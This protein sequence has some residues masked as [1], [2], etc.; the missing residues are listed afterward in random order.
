VIAVTYE[1]QL[2]CCSLEPSKQ[3]LSYGNCMPKIE[4]RATEC[5]WKSSEWLIRISIRAVA[6]QL[7]IRKRRSKRI[8]LDVEWML[9]AALRRGMAE[10]VRGRGAVIPPAGAPMD[11]VAAEWGEA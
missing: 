11:D 8:I 3:S 5:A 10:I 7:I 1:P 9:R 6:Q 4:A 2:S